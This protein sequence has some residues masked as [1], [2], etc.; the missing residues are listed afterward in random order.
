MGDLILFQADIALRQ[1]TKHLAL[2]IA[3][4][5]NAFYNGLRVC[6]FAQ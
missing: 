4:A 6:A 3:F 1:Q 5:G 2:C